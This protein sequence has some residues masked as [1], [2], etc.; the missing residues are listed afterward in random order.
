MDGR[1]LVRTVGGSGGGLG[2]GVDGK[3]AEDCGV[4]MLIVVSW[5][6]S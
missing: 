6:L 2:I 3:V 4:S 5:P 1:V